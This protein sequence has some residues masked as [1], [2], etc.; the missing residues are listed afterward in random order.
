MAQDFSGQVA[1][2]TGG[3]DGIGFATAALL[4]KRGAH[5]VICGRRAELSTPG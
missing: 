3:S 4:A 2:I 1:I 5:V